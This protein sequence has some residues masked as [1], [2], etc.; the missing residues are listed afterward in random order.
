MKRLPTALFCGAVMT[1]AALAPACKRPKPVE[2]D[3][4]QAK[5]IPRDIALAHLRKTL[6]TAEFVACTLPKDRW[7]GDEIESWTVDDAGVSFDP[8]DSDPLRVEY[9]SVTRAQLMRRGSRTFYVFLYTAEQT[10]EDREHYSFGW[11]DEE[12]A[13]QAVELFEALRQEQ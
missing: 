4:S 6:P 10:D 3:T 2:M 9:A 7:K 13:K 1:L 5:D 12:T 8:D 11:R